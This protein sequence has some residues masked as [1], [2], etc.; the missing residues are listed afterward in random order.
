LLAYSKTKAAEIYLSQQATSDSTAIQA[1]AN[2]VQ[3]NDRNH[4]FNR[5]QNLKPVAK[6]RTD[7]KR[8]SQNPSEKGYTECY[9]CESRR[10]RKA[11]CPNNA[12]LV[13]QEVEDDSEDGASFR[14]REIGRYSKGRRD[15]FMK[16]KKWKTS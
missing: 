16:G 8:G 6:K 7:Q 4:D 13:A 14:E 15:S 3:Q 2:F 9:I 11:V 1:E 5:G 12:N 10:H